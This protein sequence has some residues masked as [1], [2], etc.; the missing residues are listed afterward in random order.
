ILNARFSDALVDHRTYVIASDGDLM[1]GVS[2]EAA[3]LAGHLKLN[4]LIVL[5]DDNGISIDGP[6]ALAESTNVLKR[7]DAYGWSVSAVAGHD[8]TPVAEA[9]TRAQPS[10]KPVLIACRT[11]IG[12]GAPK[13]AGTAKAHGEALGAEEVA[14]ART[15]LGWSYPPFEIPADLVAEWR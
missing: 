7:F 9:L 3:S 4:R 8:A 5:F 13:R 10:D 6:T 12:Y 15:A 2:H 14:G 1:E 11:T